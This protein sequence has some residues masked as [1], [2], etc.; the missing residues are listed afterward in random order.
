[1]VAMTEQTESTPADAG[2]VRSNTPPSPDAGCS[3][4]T[5]GVD[6]VP[7][8]GSVVR[9]QGQ[10]CHAWRGKVVAHGPRVSGGS[11]YGSDRCEVL[12]IERGRGW[13]TEPVVVRIAI[14]VSEP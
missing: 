2:G 13:S 11:H 5:A 6:V 3:V 10:G 1:M 7:P 14:L 8:I 9:V 12:P 4:I